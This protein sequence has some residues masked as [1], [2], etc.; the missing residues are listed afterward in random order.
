MLG[1]SVETMKLERK[2]RRD[3]TCE[4]ILRLERIS[5]EGSLISLKNINFTLNKEEILGIAGLEGNGQVELGD[6]LIGTLQNSS[7]EIYFQKE[8]V[9][10]DAPHR[11]REKGLHYIPEDRIHKGLSLDMTITENAVLGHE[12]RNRIGGKNRLMDWKKAKAFTAG[13]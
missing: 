13:I 6:T 3:A 9:D 4:E 12:K 5:A 2:P 8:R 10:G 1:T 7:G 11:R